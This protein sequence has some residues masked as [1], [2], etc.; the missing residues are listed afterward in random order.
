VIENSL[1]AFTLSFGRFWPAWQKR[2]Y[3]RPRTRF[4]RSDAVANA[5]GYAK[6]RSRSHR[7]VNRVYDDAGNV[8]QT[9]EQASS[10]SS[11]KGTRCIVWQGGPNR[12][13]QSGKAV[14]FSSARTARR[15]PSSRCA[16]ALQSV[17]S[18]RSTADPQPQLQPSGCLCKFPRNLAD[19]Q[20]QLHPR[21]LRL[22]AIIFQYMSRRWSTVDK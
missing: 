9:H 18:L 4:C 20:S 21:L 11:D 6:H 5:L 12:R 10:K 17:R 15:L 8:I 14:N 7:A 1:L 22:S 19:T 2:F 16:P 13:I 3:G